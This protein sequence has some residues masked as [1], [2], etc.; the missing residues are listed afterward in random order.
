MFLP[1]LLGYDWNRGDEDRPAGLGMGRL[2][3]GKGRG[4]GV[5]LYG[6][7]AVGEVKYLSLVLISSRDSRAVTL[8][9]Y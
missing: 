7:T 5:D 4:Q 2:V 9:T 8:V 3:S 1:L 6:L